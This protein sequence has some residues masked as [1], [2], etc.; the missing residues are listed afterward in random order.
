MRDGVSKS[1]PM[2]ASAD[3]GRPGEDAGAEGDSRKQRE[4]EEKQN[5]KNISSCE[6]LIEQAT[7]SWV[8]RTSV[9]RVF[10]RSP[11]F[12]NHEQGDGEFSSNRCF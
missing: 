5:N 1:A 11:C 4:E 6:A 3:A 12:V 7:A 9:P 8:E 10:S 2:S